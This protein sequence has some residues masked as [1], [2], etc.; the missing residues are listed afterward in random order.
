MYCR[1]MIGVCRDLSFQA[2]I[3]ARDTSNGADPNN[4]GTLRDR[5]VGRQGWFALQIVNEGDFHADLISTRLVGEEEVDHPIEYVIWGPFGSYSDAKSNCATK[6]E[7][8]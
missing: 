2:N 5:G 6:T 1:D 8:G 7:V 4:Y 3:A